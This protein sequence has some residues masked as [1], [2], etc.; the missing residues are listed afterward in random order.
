[1][2]R[3]NL[4]TYSFNIKSEAGQDWIFDA[5]RKKWLLLTPEEWVRQHF[6]RYLMEDRGYPDSLIAIERAVKISGRLLRFDL[7]VFSR[8]GVPWMLVECKAPEVVINQLVF[9]QVSAY[10]LNLGAPYLVVTNGITHHCLEVGSGLPRGY[11]FLDHIPDFDFT[12]IH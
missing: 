6:V 1:M 10:N 12:E 9:D 5:L 8:S 4:P 3:L 7:L 11:R 2:Q